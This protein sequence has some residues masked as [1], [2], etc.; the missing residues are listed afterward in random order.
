MDRDEKAI[1]EARN[2]YFDELETAHTVRNIALA[3]AEDDYN[4]TR[5]KAWER[6]NL[7]ITKAGGKPTPT[8]C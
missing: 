1:Q 2:K 6:R 5:A 3:N 4:V 7:A 8:T